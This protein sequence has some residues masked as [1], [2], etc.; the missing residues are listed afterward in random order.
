MENTRILETNE[1]TDVRS[2]LRV[3]ITEMC[4][5]T[6]SSEVIEAV[7]RVVTPNHERVISMPHQ[8]PGGDISVV[9]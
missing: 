2:R 3:K 6:A 4:E 8:R 7:D 1:L 9:T 5:H